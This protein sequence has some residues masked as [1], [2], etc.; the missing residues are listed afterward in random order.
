[1][2]ADALGVGRRGRTAERVEVTLHELAVP[3][4]AGPVGTPDRPYRVP[5]VGGGQRAAVGGRHPRQRH[6]EVIPQG[7]VGLAGLLVLTAAED[8]EYEL[9]ALVAVL[10]HEDIEPLE[11]RGR[12]RLEAV[13]REHRPDM[14]ERAFP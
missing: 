6:G 3:A 7:E 2:R 11:G 9:V 8:L 12:E 13:R 10:A 1:D 14:R 4:P 5:L